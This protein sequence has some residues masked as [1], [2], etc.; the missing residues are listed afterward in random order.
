MFQNKLRH[1]DN[2]GPITNIKNRKWQ[3]GGGG[4]FE[5]HHHDK[6]AAGNAKNGNICRKT[7]WERQW[8][9][10]LE[11]LLS[12]HGSVSVYE[13]YMLLAIAGCGEVWTSTPAGKAL[14]N[15]EEPLHPNI[16]MLSNIK[17]AQ[18]SN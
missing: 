3:G 10:T 15:D 8:E 14:D 1:K 5:T 7:D 12:W 9:K 13:L 2:L 18:Q 4:A 6:K 17:Q 11:S 16:Q